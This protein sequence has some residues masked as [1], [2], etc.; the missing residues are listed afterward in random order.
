V[1]G[2]AGTTNELSW[3]EGASAGAGLVCGKKGKSWRGM[4]EAGAVLLS[5]LWGGGRGKSRCLVGCVYIRVSG[6]R[7]AG[8]R[9]E[10]GKLKH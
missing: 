1:I 10:M 7:R 2:R 3:V 9:K 8:K 5:K 6:A 4:A